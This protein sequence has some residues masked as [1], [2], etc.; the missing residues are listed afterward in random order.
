V[1]TDYYRGGT[2]IIGINIYYFLVVAFLFYGIFAATMGLLWSIGSAYFCKPEE[3][4]EYQSLHL[5]LTAVRAIFAPIFGVM[6]YE[7]LGFTGTFS[8]AAAL[9]LASVLYMVWAYRRNCGN[10][11]AFRD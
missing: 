11:L 1:A 2:Q 6:I 5:F 7:W 9:L 8:T 10:G 3:A 4:S